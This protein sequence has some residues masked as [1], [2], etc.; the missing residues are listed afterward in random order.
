MRLMK[1]CKLDLAGQLY[2][3]AWVGTPDCICKTTV[4]V[5]ITQRATVWGGCATVN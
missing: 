5:H 4:V 3:G 2:L 1:Q